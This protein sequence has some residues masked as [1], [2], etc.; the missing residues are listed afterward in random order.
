MESNGKPITF[1][2]S[3]EKAKKKSLETTDKSENQ[4]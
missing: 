2:S 4:L 3:D 1:L